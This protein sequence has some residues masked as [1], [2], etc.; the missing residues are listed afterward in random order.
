LNQ[1]LRPAHALKIPFQGLDG[2]R[3]QVQVAQIEALD[4][5]AEA[6][7]TLERDFQRMSRAQELIEL[8]SGLAAG[9]TGDE[10]VQGRVAALLREARQLESIDAASKPLADRLSSAAVELNELG[11]EFSTLSQELQFDP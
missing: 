5:T 8:A 6:I 3:R 10:G 7:E 11:A 4:L 2:L 1:F 9:L